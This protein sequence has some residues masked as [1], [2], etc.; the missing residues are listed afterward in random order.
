M[1]AFITLFVIGILELLGFQVLYFLGRG[2]GWLVR[3]PFAK[4]EKNRQPSERH[5]LDMI[6]GYS[7]VIALLI[8][9][10]LLG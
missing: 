8:S 6:V 2:I 1:A 5:N 9:L 7:V 10:A 3:I 4:S